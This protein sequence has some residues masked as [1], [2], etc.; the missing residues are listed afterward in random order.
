[1]TYFHVKP[2]DQGFIRLWLDELPAGIGVVLGQC[3]H[4]LVSA[5]AEVFLIHAPLLVYDEC[6][7]T[8]VPPLCRICEQS[9]SGNHISVDDVVVLPPRGR[10]VLASLGF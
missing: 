7:Y 9:E 6:H 8:R 4:G 2:L 3:A 10:W 5:W 1:M